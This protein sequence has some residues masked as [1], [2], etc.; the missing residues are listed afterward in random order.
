MSLVINTNIASLTAQRALH[1]TGD[2]LATA[3]ERLATGSKN[4]SSA[5][6]AAGPAHG[7]RMT[8]P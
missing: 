6:D 5:D 3:M 7:H 4:N 8:A 1:G 2:E